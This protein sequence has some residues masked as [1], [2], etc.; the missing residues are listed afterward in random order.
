[1]ARHTIR[2]VWLKSPS[3]GR[4]NMGR[5]TIRSI[6]DG[7]LGIRWTYDL[8]RPQR[9]VLGLALVMKGRRLWWERSMGLANSERVSEPGR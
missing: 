6:V 9:R 5:N 1:M 3:E 8:M 2:D 7:R 4:S